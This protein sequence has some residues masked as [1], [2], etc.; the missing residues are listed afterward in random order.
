MAP[1]SGILSL[2]R[3]QRF[4]LLMAMWTILGLIDASQFYVHVNYF[5]S[6]TMH[7]EE[8]LV[9]G[10]ADWYVWALL[11]PFIFHL[12][13]RFPITG[14]HWPGWLL[15]HA[16]A[17]AGFVLLKVALDLPLAFLIHRQD[18]LLGASLQDTQLSQ[19]ARYVASYVTVKSFIYLIVYSAIVGSAHLLDFYQKYRERELFAAQLGERLAE[20]RLLVL[21]MQLHP[22]FLFNTLNAIS[23]L[24]HSDVRLADR[25]LA[26]LAELLRAT[27]A[28]PGSQEVT[29]RRELAFLT[30]YLEIEQARLGDRLNVTVDVPAD[31]HTARLPYLLLQPLV[32]NAIRH[33]IAP[34]SGQ[35]K[36][37]VRA[38]RRGDRLE[39]EV[40][41]DGAGLPADEPFAEGIGLSNTRARLRGLYGDDQS[42][43]LRSGIGRG[44][45]VTVS[46]PY[47][48]AAP[49]GD[50]RPAAV[51]NV[52]AVGSSNSP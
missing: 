42:L 47:R 35:G 32:E 14:P 39:L 43:T 38:R 10:L 36:L 23:A 1:P 40:A 8:A 49:E 26:R 48:E 7:W 9:S 19:L 12:G 17:G 11:A 52:A 6:R 20:S 45:T 31:L 29:L 51:D 15:F 46:L 4:G 2:T 25:M 41:D 30:P 21:R 28:D 3:W 34:R 37:D 16:V 18:P 24:M 44:L 13:R 27:L 50:G 22:H 33:G 5:R